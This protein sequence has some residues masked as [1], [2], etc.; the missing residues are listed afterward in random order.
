MKIKTGFINPPISDR[1]YD[2]IAFDDETYGG[3]ESDVVGYGKDEIAAIRDLL[4]N[5]E[6]NMSEA[7]Y[8]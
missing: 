2:W 7:Q 5:I 6:A 3:E 1:K 8:T 4:D